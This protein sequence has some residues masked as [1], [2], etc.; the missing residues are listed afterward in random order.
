MRVLAQR[1]KQKGA[2]HR[3]RF[4]PD[5]PLRAKRGWFSAASFASALRALLAEATS[6]RRS[7][8]LLCP[9][10]AMKLKGEGAKTGKLEFV[11]RAV[12]RHFRPP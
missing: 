11:P 6:T 9:S 7:T 3:G 4:N 2:T 5:V 1:L 10:L 12:C 8:C